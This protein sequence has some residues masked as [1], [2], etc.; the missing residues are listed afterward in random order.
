MKKRWEERACAGGLN[1]GPPADDDRAR[2][3]YHDREEITIAWGD[4]ILSPGSPGKVRCLFTPR[5]APDTGLT[6]AR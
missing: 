2:Q 3:L 1:A 6:C 4:Q 5:C